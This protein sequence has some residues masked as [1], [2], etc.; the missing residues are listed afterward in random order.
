MNRQISNILTLLGYNPSRVARSI[1][2]ALGIASPRRIVSRS[3]HAAQNNR[4]SADFTGASGNPDAD[5]LSALRTVRNKARE[6]SQNDDYAKQYLR[7]LVINVVG[8]QG[9]KL[10]A[11]IRNDDGTPDS[12]ASTAIETAWKN[13]SRP[14]NC[15]VTG[16]HSFR[17]MQTLLI[18]HAGR[19][20]EGMIRS[21]I[22]K[23]A[24]SGILFQVHEPEV[25]DETLN[26]RI[27]DSVMIKMGVEMDGY[28]RPL[29]YH[30]R[31]RSTFA[32]PYT[33]VEISPE[34]ERIPARDL[35]HGFDQEYINQTRGI[36]WVV[37]SMIRLR[38]LSGY[39]EAALVNARTSAS[40]MGF[41]TKE[42]DATGE[43]TGDAEDASG[44]TISEAEPGTFEQLPPGFDF[45][46][47]TPEYPTAQHE[48]FIKATLRGAAS[49]LGVSYN[50]LS[51]DLEGV[52]YSSIRA[53]LLE[54]RENWKFLQ[55]WYAETFLD[56]IFEL[57]LESAM[58]KGTLN[59]PFRKF[60]KFNRPIWIGRRWAWVDPLKDV[61]AK[62]LEVEAG[63]ETATQVIAEKG[64]D[65]VELYQ[66]LEQEQKLREKY[67]VTVKMDE[68]KALLSSIN[69]DT[70]DEN[71][72]LQILRDF[73]AILNG[74]K[75]GV[76][77]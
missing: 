22:D 68:V 1:G 17:A 36:S 52:N 18:R 53:G 49:G 65:I 57:W 75:N 35:I 69:T 5:I 55:T 77:T 40:K 38:M 7:Q 34:R 44:N 41:F 23:N 16:K 71:R 62:I 6:L 9:F 12:V 74:K 72:A 48:A 45:K 32:S 2:R 15:S 24:H 27:S 25:L 39:E 66:E 63:F 50:L 30:L 61:T 29:A 60:E 14:R 20:G 21:V 31:K 47:F 10:Q 37:Q 59:L 46:P 11:D 58:A 26:R 33:T 3:Y 64:E 70:K 76:H 4:L 8:P 43:I 42:T 13:W 73:K 56:P 54:E 51:G 67:N 19:D 28:R